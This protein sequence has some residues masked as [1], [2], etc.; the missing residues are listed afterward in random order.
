MD[1]TNLLTDLQS[2]LLSSFAYGN[3]AASVS[4]VE[5]MYIGQNKTL[6]DIATDML[7]ETWTFSG[8]GGMSNKEYKNILL[9]ISND[10]IISRKA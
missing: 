2:W 10:P 1:N 3:V 5:K 4:D 6:G 7:E 8:Y 9:E